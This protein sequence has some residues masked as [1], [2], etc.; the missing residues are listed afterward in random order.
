MQ[1]GLN[2]DDDVSST[3]E[4]ISGWGWWSPILDHNRPRIAVLML[5]RVTVHGKDTYII[6]PVYAEA[7]PQ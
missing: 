1:Y 2:D 7:L 5:F 6:L 3:L 4:S